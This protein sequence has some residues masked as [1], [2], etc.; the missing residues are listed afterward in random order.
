VSC[1]QR[2]SCG[3]L[4]IC[5]RSPL[6]AKTALKLYGTGRVNPR[7]TATLFAIVEETLVDH[8]GD[9]ILLPEFMQMPKEVV[10]GILAKAHSRYFS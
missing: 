5:I 1:L 2:L 4:P 9:L 6:C 8:F 3:W 7:T 10:S